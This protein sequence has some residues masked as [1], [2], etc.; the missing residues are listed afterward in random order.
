MSAFMCTGVCEQWTD[1]M[2]TTKKVYHQAVNE[3]EIIWQVMDSNLLEQKVDLDHNC[4]ESNGWV[5]DSLRS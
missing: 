1:K 4:V 2:V 5:Q 3:E